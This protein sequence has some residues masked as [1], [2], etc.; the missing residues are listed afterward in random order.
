MAQKQAPLK[1]NIPKKNRIRTIQF[2][3]DMI[4]MDACDIINEELIENLHETLMR[5]NPNP[6]KNFRGLSISI[7]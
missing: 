2:S 7:S 6:C 3:C 5:D 4:V 1:I